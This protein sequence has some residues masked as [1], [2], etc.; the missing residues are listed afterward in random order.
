MQP[1]FGVSL[2]GN[3]NIFIDY[4]INNEVIEQV[5]QE[6]YE[7]IKVSNVLYFCCIDNES[8]MKSK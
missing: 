1:L 6:F 2:G 5:I 4:S 3:S 8:A 7:V